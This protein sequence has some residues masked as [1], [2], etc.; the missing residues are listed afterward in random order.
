[1][2]KYIATPNSEIIGA[3]MQNFFVSQ[4]TQ[5]FDHVVREI[6]NVYGIDKFNED[7]WYPVELA[8]E[9]FKAIE[10]RTN[11]QNLVALGVAYVDT[12]LFPPEVNSIE[13][14]LT[15]LANTYDINCR[16]VAK[17]EGYTTKIIDTDHIQVEDYNPF[18]HDV[19][20]GFIWGL[21]RRFKEKG[22]HFSVHRE[23]MSPENPD[24]RG[25]IYNIYIER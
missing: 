5:P 12:A 3:T 17:D 7:E 9:L 22:E 14:G 11:K 10:M 16:N 2:E 25:A 6:L 13:S 18:P 15:L 1:M 21:C 20:Y 23:Y 19:V 8:L 4:H 24:S